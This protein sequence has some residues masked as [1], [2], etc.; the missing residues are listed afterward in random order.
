MLHVEHAAIL[1]CDKNRG[2][3]DRGD[4]H[5]SI[6]VVLLCFVV[7]CAYAARSIVLVLDWGSL[8]RSKVSMVYSA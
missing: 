4:V 2:S 6:D 5:H 3:F 8:E 1:C 7:L